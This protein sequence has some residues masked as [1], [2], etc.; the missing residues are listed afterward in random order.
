VEDQKKLDLKMAAS[1]MNAEQR[2]EILD[3][4]ASSD[5]ASASAA[6]SSAAQASYADTVTGSNSKAAEAEAATTIMPSLPPVE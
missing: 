4:F 6:S 1:K 2:A 3:S 5:A